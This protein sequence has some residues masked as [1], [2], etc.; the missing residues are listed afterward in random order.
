MRSLPSLPTRCQW[1]SVTINSEYTPPGSNRVEDTTR[2]SLNGKIATVTYDQL[3]WKF[4][5]AFWT[6]ENKAMLYM[7]IDGSETTSGVEPT[8][9]RY[10]G[11]IPYV[12]EIP[13]F[14]FNNNR[15]TSWIYLDD[16]PTAGTLTSE[17][18]L[19]FIMPEPYE[20]ATLILRCEGISATTPISG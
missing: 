14:R 19:T 6:P 8:G 18:A 15:V 5:D 7:Y 17:L 16:K 3:K 20:N 9:I 13:S 10:S 1:N 12:T 11:T 2:A 4:D